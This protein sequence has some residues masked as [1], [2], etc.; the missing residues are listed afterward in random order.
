MFVLEFKGLQQFFLV[1]CSP[2]TAADPGEGNWVTSSP[3][4]LSGHIVA[5]Q[6]LEFD[7][8]KF[9][10]SS[11]PLPIDNPGSAPESSHPDSPPKDVK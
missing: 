2:V 6:H 5:F 8:Y 10:K 11:P 7:Y 1:L 9:G 3:F 4:F